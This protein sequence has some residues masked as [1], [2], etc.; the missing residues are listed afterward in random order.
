MAVHRRMARVLDMLHTLPAPAQ[1]AIIASLP[2]DDRA[3]AADPARAAE[4]S[5]SLAE[6]PEAPQEQEPAE[7]GED[8]TDR[9][10]GRRRHSRAPRRR[11]G[12]GR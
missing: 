1:Q 10:L 6:P 2:A 11:A 3:R 12:G 5:A 4:P 7:R 9:L 8:L